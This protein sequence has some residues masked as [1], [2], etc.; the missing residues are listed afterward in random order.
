MNKKSELDCYMFFM[1]NVWGE[2]ECMNI[3]G[4]SLGKHIWSKWADHCD[5]VGRTGAAATMYAVL[6]SDKR[7]KIVERA[8]AHYNK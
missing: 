5:G 2:E 8:V 7:R 1:W 4:E 3:F 6:D